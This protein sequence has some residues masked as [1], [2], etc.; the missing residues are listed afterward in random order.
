[1]KRF[2]MNKRS[3]LLYLKKAFLLGYVIV[4]LL[5]LIFIAYDVMLKVNGK[6][7][8]QK[9]GRFAS[10]TEW[11][12][13][14]KEQAIHE[15]QNMPRMM[16]NLG[17]P[18]LI[19]QF[20]IDKDAPLYAWQTGG[21]LL[22]LYECTTEVEFE[23]LVN[24]RKDLQNM[25]GEEIDSALLAYALSFMPGEEYRTADRIRKN[26]LED[27]SSC[28]DPGTGTIMYREV[29]PSFRFIDTIGLVCPF[30]AVLGREEGNDSYTDLALAQLLEF[31]AVAFDEDYDYLPFHAY[32]LASKTPL[33]KY[34][35]GRGTGWY[36]LGIIDTYLAL[37][38]S[39][40]PLLQDSILKLAETLKKYQREDGGW[41]S[42]VNDA[43][44]RT[45]TSATA[46]FLYF[47]K[48]AA[49]LGL[50]EAV[51]YEDCIGRAE[52]CLMNNTHRDGRVMNT[53][54]DCIAI[55]NYS[56]DYKHMPFTLG[57]TLRAVCL[58]Q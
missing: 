39:R 38:E 28:T 7:M 20:K 57:M 15:Y 54:G 46:L 21:L 18:R 43:A 29:Y 26:I 58:N 31:E 22:G 10:R 44:S 55:G 48:R 23:E 6:L 42:T 52:L 19:T 35:W 34:G 49:S 56:Y 14:M 36:A 11:I 16:G 2:Q 13:A 32:D 25:T 30:L 9:L 17:F 3:I 51:A 40:R 41:G 24:K 53:E 8:A 12:D 5:A 50:I 45:E 33:G 47:I 27:I 4:S 1:M 37:D